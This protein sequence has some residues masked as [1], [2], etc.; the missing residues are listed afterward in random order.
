MKEKI[1]KGRRKM[2]TE[3]VV[4]NEPHAST[5]CSLMRL[6]KELLRQDRERKKGKN[7]NCPE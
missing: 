1:D 3:S 4:L 6:Y 2:G 7:E 5:E